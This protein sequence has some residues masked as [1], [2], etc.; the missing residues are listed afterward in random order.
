M[1]TFDYVRVNKMEKAKILLL[2]SHKTIKEI[3]IECGYA[4]S[5]TFCRQ[6][7]RYVGDSPLQ[8]RKKGKR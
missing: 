3:A 7:K 2:E 1:S 4:N 6:F 8:Y 5:I